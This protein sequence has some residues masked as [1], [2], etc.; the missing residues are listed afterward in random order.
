[1]LEAAI[2]GNL[3]PVL[4]R[5]FN[6]SSP[7]GHGTALPVIYTYSIVPSPGLPCSMYTNRRYLI[8]PRSLFWHVMMRL[9]LSSTSLARM[10][11]IKRPV[12]SGRQCVYMAPAP[13][14]LAAIISFLAFYGQPANLFC[15]LHPP[16]RCRRRRIS[17][18]RLMPD[19][20]NRLLST[21]W[22]RRS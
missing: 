19:T 16:P 15:D 9:A 20:Q 7:R 18:R 4:Q 8:T 14:S 13:R 5:V 10:L 12:E 2:G 6:F 17:H 1:M 22:T 3:D 21:I 11:S